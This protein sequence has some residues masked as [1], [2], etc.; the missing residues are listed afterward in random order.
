[1]LRNLGIKGTYE[2]LYDKVL[3]K[4][5]FVYSGDGGGFSDNGK[6]DIELP[7]LPA[8]SDDRTEYILQMRFVGVV[9]HE[10]LH[11]A[12][13]GHDDMATAAF[14][15]LTPAERQKHARGKGDDDA[16]NYM[17]WWVNEKCK[18]NPDDPAEVKA[19]L[20]KP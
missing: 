9:I 13:K 17:S 3:E 8:A 18:F 15:A 11:R 6:G 19:K 2:Q 5:G 14:K 10:L 20:V 7:T 12:N 4:H 1:M 16:S